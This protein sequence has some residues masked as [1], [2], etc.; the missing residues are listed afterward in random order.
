[1]LTFSRAAYSYFDYV[2]G[3]T[4]IL[5]EHLWHDVKDP[6]TYA[7]TNPVGTGAYTLT[8]FSP[9]AMTLTA[10]PHYYLPGYPKIKTWRY[11]ALNGNTAT[12]LAIE[13]GQLAWG[14]SY[15][16][17][18][19]QDYLDKN[20]KYAV[21]DNPLQIAYLIP[22]MT[23]GPT[24]D[25]AVREA[26]SDAINRSF[27]SKDV[28]NGYAGPTNPE[29]VLTPT[30]S[31]ILDPALSSDTLSYDPAAAKRILESDGYTPGSGGMMEKDGHELTIDVKVVSTF[32]NYVQDIDII[33][34]EEKAAGINMVVDLESRAQFTEDEDN[35]N[36]QMVIGKYGSTASPYVFFNGLLNGADI[37]P[38]GQTDTVG[39]YGRYNN[40]TVDSMLS[41]ISQTDNLSAQKQ[42]FYQIEKDFEQVMPD[43]PLFNQQDEEEFNGNLIAGW[44]TASNPYAPGCAMSTRPDIGW[45]AMRLTGAK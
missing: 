1:M 34:A 12:E 4:Y 31:D 11:V 20:P 28:Y 33:A 44:P 35:G 43:I 38:V 37:P 7:D 3:E 6:A 24:T 23:S 45:C 18:I 9:T 26:I 30:F 19:Q 14:G 41:A 25:L 15:I 5:P 36:F 27:V 22:N 8:S 13:T 17:N 10:N 2:A 42:D 21:T 40:S 39:D 29:S 32:T 16:P